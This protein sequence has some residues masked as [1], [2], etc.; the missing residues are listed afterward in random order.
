M[1]VSQAIA[2]WRHSTNLSLSDAVT[3]WLLSVGHQLVGNI[4][5]VALSII[6][7][8]YS[9]PAGTHDISLLQNGYRT[10]RTHVFLQ[11]STIFGR[12]KRWS[13]LV[14]PSV[15]PT[16]AVTYTSTSRPRRHEKSAVLTI[17]RFV[18]IVLSCYNARPQI[19][20]SCRLP[21]S[22]TTLF[23]SAFITQICSEIHVC[24]RLWALIMWASAFVFRRHR[25]AISH[26]AAASRLSCPFVCPSMTSG[27]MIT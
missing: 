2:R 1:A 17:F 18:I 21:W 11:L 15:R 24:V 8:A 22:L 12:I 26:I 10:F 27:I 16:L 9:A 23:G 14:H 4:F 5:L 7:F 20:H 13:V 25:L 6:K 3:R 19:V